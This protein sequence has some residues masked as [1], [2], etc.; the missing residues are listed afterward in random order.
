MVKNLVIIQDS[1]INTYNPDFR[2]NANT[3]IEEVLQ[4]KYPEEI[5][6]NA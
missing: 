4:S 2:R 6:E 3:L 1:Y 5:E